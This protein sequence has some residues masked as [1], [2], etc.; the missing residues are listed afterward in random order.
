MKKNNIAAA[1]LIST[2][3][4]T[5]LMNTGMTVSHAA[6]KDQVETKADL[7]EVTPEKVVLD[8]QN[9]KYTIPNVVG[10][11]YKINDKDADPGEYELKDN[12]KDVITAYAKEGY[13][14]K[15][16]SVTKWT[17]TNTSSEGGEN[18]GGE[19]QSK[20]IVTIQTDKEFNGQEIDYSSTAPFSMKVTNVANYN[21]DSGQKD[22]AKVTY[23]ITQTFDDGKEAG[24]F[25]VKPNDESEITLTP[26]NDQANID[27]TIDNAKEK[28][29]DQNGDLTKNEPVNIK[30]T[31]F[32]NGEEIGSESARFIDGN[33]DPSNQVVTPE[34]P[35]LNNETGK[36][37]IPEVTGVEYQIDGQTVQAGDYDLGVN[38]SVEI[39]SIPADGYI[40]SEGAKTKWT[41][42]RSGDQSDLIASVAAPTYNAESGTFTIPESENYTYQINGEVYEA[43]EYT[44]NKGQTVTI[45][46][47]P[48]EGFIIPDDIQ[49][50]WTFTNENESDKTPKGANTYSQTG[51]AAAGLGAMAGGSTVLGT[52]L[53]MMKKKFKK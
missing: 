52:A 25:N 16:G 1:L 2:M 19:N 13:K 42:T 4:L 23:S 44:L 43:G 21:K 18:E 5:P 11:G 26:E 36:Y 47:V 53:A 46:A 31:F 33:Y 3:V 7:I 8:K 37:T 51:V 30:I 40:F 50:E 48:D 34:D 29:V 28:D 39:T 20:S 10:V 9:K 22:P 24:I 27:F 41:L 14:L 49:S 12:T 45:K 32:A 38:E 15:S 35:T 6:E 17:F